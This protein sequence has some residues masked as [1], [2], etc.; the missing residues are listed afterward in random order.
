MIHELQNF[1]SAQ[2]VKCREAYSYAYQAGGPRYLQNCKRAETMISKWMRR[3][4]K[5]AESPRFREA[6][7]ELLTRPKSA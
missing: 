4:R 5:V 3:S 6:M 1:C 7:L 2:Q